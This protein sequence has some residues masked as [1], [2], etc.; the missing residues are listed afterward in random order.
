MIVPRPPLIIVFLLLLLRPSAAHA[1]KADEVRPIIELKQSC[2]IGGVKGRRWIDA[3]RLTKSIN[4]PQKLN[5]YTLAGPAG[6]LTID[7]ITPGDCAGEW[8]FETSAQDAEGIAI[9]SPSWDVMPRTPRLLDRKDTT[10]V[11]ILADLLRRA[12]IRKPEVEINEGYKIDLD[13]DGKDEVVIVASHFKDG[14]GELSGI[15]RGS[16]PGDYAIVLVRKMVN[17]QVRNIFLVKD[18][19]RTANAGPLV[20]GYH[21]SAIADLN[22]DG[23]MEIVLYDAYHEGSASHVIQINGAKPMFVLECACEH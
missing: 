7:K 19:R 13:G 18:V 8:S 4:T 23:V 21:L 11:N 9:A 2:V 22:G 10:Y 16:A 3:E 1:Q 14:T 12:G 20:R 15:G 17:G 5:R 6:E